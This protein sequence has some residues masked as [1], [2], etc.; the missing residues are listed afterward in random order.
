MEHAGFPSDETLAAYIDGRLDKKT[1]RR[2]VEHIEQCEECYAVVVSAAEFRDREGLTPPARSPR[3]RLMLVAA[4]IMVAVLVAVAAGVVAFRHGNASGTALLAQSVGAHRYIEPRLAGFP[5]QPLQATRGTQ[6][7]TRNPENWRLV[8]AGARVQEE[9]VKR[10][11]PETL[12][13]LGVSHLLYGNLDDAVKKLGEA[14]EMESGASN[15]RDALA[16]AHDVGLLIDLAAAYE[17]RAAQTSNQRDR[18]TA[19]E[20]I[21]RTLKLA[22]RS[23]EVLWNHALVIEGL[24]LREDAAAAW[25]A[26]LRVDPSSRWALEAREHLRHLREPTTSELWEHDRLLLAAAALAGDQ[27]RVNELAGRY[28]WQART[29]GEGELLP[30]WGRTQSADTLTIARAVGHALVHNS[31]ER[32]LADSVAAIDRATGPARDAL[33]E[34]HVAYGKGWKLFEASDITNAM[35][36]LELAIAKLEQGGSALTASAH[37]H[38]AAC[39]FMRNQ[40][41]EAISE[42]VRVKE[43]ERGGRHFAVL[44]RADWL[45][46][47]IEGH[48]GHPNEALDCYQRSF[49]RFAALHEDDNVAAIHGLVADV[50]DITGE[51]DDAISHAATAL[52]IV[53]RTGSRFRF[54]QLLYTAAVNCV[55]ERYTAAAELMLNRLAQFDGRNSAPA[56]TCETCLMLAVIRARRGDRAG[57]A[58]AIRAANPYCQ[59]IRDEAQRQRLV[60]FTTAAMIASGAVPF[61]ATTDGLTRAINF[62]HSSGS[63]VALAQLYAERGEVWRARGQSEL[64]EHDFE[65]SVEEMEAERSHAFDAFVDIQPPFDSMLRLFVDQHRYADALLVADRSNTL[66]LSQVVALQSPTNQ[67]SSVSLQSMLPS[68][69]VVAEYHVTNDSL[70]MWLVTRDVIVFREVRTTPEEIQA[71]IAAIVSTATT[72]ADVSVLRSASRKAGQLLLAPWIG[73]IRPDSTI[74]FVPDGVIDDVPFAAI[75]NPATNHFLIEEHPIATS[76]TLAAFV[77]SVATD[78]MRGYDSD[79]LFASPTTTQMP[80]LPFTEREIEDSSSAWG[81]GTL[82]RGADATKEAFLAHSPRAAIIHFAGHARINERA[83]MM[84]ALVFRDSLLYLHELSEKSFAHARLFVLAAC[85]TGRQPRPGMSFAAALTAHGVPSVVASLWDADD[86]S[87]ARLFNVF[88]QELRRGAGRAVALQRAQLSL[89]FAADPELQKPAC[90]SGYQMIGAIGPIK[91]EEKKDVAASHSHHRHLRVHARSPRT[92]SRAAHV[93]PAGGTTARLAARGG[94]DHSGPSAVP[95]RACGGHR[96]AARY[97]SAV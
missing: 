74:V 87:S 44:A 75:V 89:L 38:H 86:H 51:M 88:H 68:N 7:L 22:P 33:A 20:V 84:S 30:E 79:A 8:A 47:L 37:V 52:A 61:P 65:K 40:Y 28:P 80:A 83:P 48:L 57:A 81:R 78:A 63:R 91:R 46:G 21:A 85:G 60:S 43:A 59:S 67:T 93:R 1:R 54:H 29:W 76:S 4:A 34:G 56:G 49:A 5:Y 18:Y 24:H 9:A 69:T 45:H 6:E 42:L 53:A 14:L 26:Y 97:E 2:V 31:G 90:W 64:A 92:A 55:H 16:K 3:S 19:E 23:P 10:R 72:A 39:H 35:P 62:F 32:M 94:H 27:E 77:H 41:A 82:L 96:D 36:E 73:S 17:T 12:H 70:M 71:A 11:T 66:R 15:V 13:A 58:N 25:E 95:R 50:L